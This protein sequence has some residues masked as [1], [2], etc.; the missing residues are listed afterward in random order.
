MKK[1]I[2]LIVVL[3]AALGFSACGKVDISGSYR[4]ISL[5]ASAYDWNLDPSLDMLDDIILTVKDKEATL[6]LPDDTIALTVDYRKKVFT[7]EEGLSA[8]Y[9]YENGTLTLTS[10]AGSEMV[11]ERLDTPAKSKKP[12]N[13]TAD[14]K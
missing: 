13:S 7:D 8:P 12:T 4:L 1:L 14:S 10:S 5:S 6:A 2:V 3:C 9:L 11:F